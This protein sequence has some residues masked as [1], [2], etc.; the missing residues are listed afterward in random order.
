M[1]GVNARAC[2]QQLTN[3]LALELVKKTAGAQHV[4]FHC[5]GTLFTFSDVMVQ[6]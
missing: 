6:A 4:Q 5:T 1:W 2:T 3:A